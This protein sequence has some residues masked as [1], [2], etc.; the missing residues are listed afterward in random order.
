MYCELRLRSHSRCSPLRRWH[1]LAQPLS[2]ERRLN[3]AFGQ[4]DAQIPISG[5]RRP[6]HAADVLVHKST[7]AAGKRHGG[8]GQIDCQVQR[9]LLVQ[10]DDRIGDVMQG[11]GD[12]RLQQIELPVD[13]CQHL[14]RSQFIIHALIDVQM[15]QQLASL[16]RE[17]RDAVAAWFDPHVPRPHKAARGADDM[18]GF[19]HRETV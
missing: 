11:P 4:I 3:Q 7:N 19:S 12:D 13:N 5:C 6:F 2:P 17:T 10:P 1:K 8:V 14:V 9:R 18:T 16:G 15:I